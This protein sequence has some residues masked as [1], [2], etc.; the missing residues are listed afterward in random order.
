M[1]ACSRDLDRLKNAFTD[2]DVTYSACDA[3]DEGAFK[4]FV[5]FVQER[6]KYVDVL[7][8]CAGGFG[9]IG[10]IDKV[11]SSAWVRT[12]SDNLSATFLPCKFF[13]PLL[14]QSKTPQI[15][16]FSGGGAFYP[17]PN[18]TAYACAKAAIVRLTE[19]LALELAPYGI[20]VNAIAPGFVRTNA[21]KSIMDAGP[22]RAGIVQFRR[23]ERLTKSTDVDLEKHKLEAVFQCIRALMSP[24]Y[25]NLTGKTI[26]TNFD[27]WSTD[28]FR[29]HIDEI[30]RSDLYTMRRTN[31]VNLPEGPLKNIFLKI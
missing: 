14:Q 25:Y 13:L 18:F 5:E 10:S 2:C 6:S 3:T 7:I 16:N 28:A 19:T 30:T 9:E 20:S 24:S 29:E 27:P 23:A 26:S 17:F 15:I 1:F 12:V 21:Q 4:K 22:D 8:N 31:L 11:E